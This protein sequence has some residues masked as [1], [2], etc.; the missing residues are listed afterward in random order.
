MVAV[1]VTAVSAIGLTEPKL[2]AGAVTV[3][4]SAR[5]LAQGAASATSRPNAHRIRCRNRTHARRCFSTRSAAD[6]AIP[7]PQNGYLQ[8][9]FKNTKQS[10]SDTNNPIPNKNFLRLNHGPAHAA[11]SATIYQPRLFL[12]CTGDTL[13]RL[14]GYF[15][16]DFQV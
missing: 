15:L 3:Q 4:V 11:I 9:H 7:T 5:A 2:G 8:F 12:T 6:S 16:I 1:V 14:L 13:I 10:H